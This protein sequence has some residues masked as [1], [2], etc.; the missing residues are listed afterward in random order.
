[1]KI[2]SAICRLLCVT[3]LLMATVTANADKKKK[4]EAQ[5]IDIHNVTK[6]QNLAFP[7]VPEKQRKFIADY[8]LREAQNILKQ[9]YRVETERQGEVVV[10][11][12]PASKLFAP[13]STELEVSGQKL[14]EPFTAYLKTAG[15]FKV[16]VAVHSD[17]TGSE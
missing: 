14:I 12:I 5:A 7:T 3:M 4:D 10:V 11:T 16:I 2:R 13:N 15:R 8:M 17:D 1:M 9:G 6:A